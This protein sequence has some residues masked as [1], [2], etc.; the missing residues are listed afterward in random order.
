L[1]E[2]ESPLSLLR[3]LLLFRSGE[4]EKRKSRRSSECE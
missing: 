1:C 4:R 3:L 2:R